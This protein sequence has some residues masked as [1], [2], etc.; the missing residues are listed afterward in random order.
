MWRTRLA[1]LQQPKQAANSNAS[2]T[3]YGGWP[4]Y[5][6]GDGT[7]GTTGIARAADQSSTFQITSRPAADTPNRFSIEFQDA[8][9]SYQQDSVT[10]VDP[11]DVQAVGFQVSAT[12]N[13]LGVPNYDQALRIVSLC[14]D[15]STAGNTYIEFQTSVRALGIQPGDIVAVTHSLEGYGSHA[16]SG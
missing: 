12:P 7:N 10:L 16:L 14:L 4:V 13:A 8:F 9:N 2:T 5:E 6:F 1:A 11:D 15:K 3:L